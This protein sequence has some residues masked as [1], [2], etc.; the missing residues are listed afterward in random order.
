MIPGIHRSFLFLFIFFFFPAYSQDNSGSV[1]ESPEKTAA[2]DEVIPEPLV[3]PFADEP[4]TW[5]RSNALGQPLEE[6]IWYRASLMPWSLEKESN[7][8]SE[9]WILYK[10]G[11]QVK[12]WLYTY[13]EAQKLR[14]IKVFAQGETESIL[15]FDPQGRLNTETDFSQGERHDYQYF[16]QRDQVRGFRFLIDGVEEYSQNLYR[17]QQGRLRRIERIMKDGSVQMEGWVYGPEG[18]VSRWSKEGDQVDSVFNDRLGNPYLEQRFESQILIYESR[19]TFRNGRLIEEEILDPR[20]SEQLLQEFDENGK[21]IKETLREMGKVLVVNSYQYTDD[22]LLQ[23]TTET[24]TYKEVSF[25]TYQDDALTEIR[26]TRNGLLHRLIVFLPEDIREESWY[27]KGELFLKITFQEEE[28]IRE[29][30]FQY[31]E[32]FRSETPGE[33]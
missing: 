9:T 32:I 4:S 30:F 15:A 24:P 14:E 25:Y 19:K 6:I 16:Y 3:T 10:E 13:A 12:L 8:L 20:A 1:L 23:Q 33:P 18:L 26:R 22:R 2:D 21:L 27:D 29:D 28:K 17:D 31:G 5:Y 7:E 11:V